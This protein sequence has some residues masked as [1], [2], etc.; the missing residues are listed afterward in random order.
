MEVTPGTLWRRATSRRA[1]PSSCA[2]WRV[3]PSAKKSIASALRRCSSD[4]A[5]RDASALCVA[6]VAGA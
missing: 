3:R 4:R 1:R 6:G 5:A 2:L